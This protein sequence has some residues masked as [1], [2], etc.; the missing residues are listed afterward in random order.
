MPLWPTN[1][2]VSQSKE[3]SEYY[4]RQ[5]S[6]Q[7]AC[8]SRRGWFKLHGPMQKCRNAISIGFWSVYTSRGRKPFIKTT[9]ALLAFGSVRFFGVFLLRFKANFIVVCNGHLHFG[10]LSFQNNGSRLDSCFEDMVRCLVAIS[11]RF[12]CFN[13][14]PSLTVKK[15]SCDPGHFYLIKFFITVTTLTAGRAKKDM[16]KTEKQDAMVFPIH[17]WGTLS[18]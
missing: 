17:V 12:C 4:F 10:V 7:A 18:P 6:T 8:A 2:T 9:T 16:A 3:Y 15:W 5:R 13:C 14:L 1:M 11:C